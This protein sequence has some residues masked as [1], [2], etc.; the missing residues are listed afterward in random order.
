MDVPPGVACLDTRHPRRLLAPEQVL[1][2]FSIY[3]RPSP[4][5]LKTLVVGYH[6]R[7]SRK[8]E[9]WIII[10]P[11]L[12]EHDAPKCTGRP[13]IDQR[14]ALDAIIFRMRSGC[15]WNSCPRKSSPTT[16][17]CTA[18]CR[19]GS[20]LACSISSGRSSSRSARNSAE[21]TSSGRPPMG[22]WARHTL[23]GSRRPQSHRQSQKRAQTLPAGRGRW[24]SSF[25][26]DS[27]SERA[28]L[29]AVGGHARCPIVVGWP[30]PNEQAPCYEHLC[31]DKGYD[32]APARE[33]VEQR[34]YVPHI[35][36]I[37]E[38]KLDDAGV[39]RYPALGGGTYTGLAVEMPGHTGTLR[40]EG[41]QLP[42]ADQG[43]LHPAVVSAS[44]SSI[45]FEIVC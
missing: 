34:G 37:G 10:E 5:Y 32:K 11:I 44:A 19:G 17:R 15:Q 28:R 35:R 26:G 42:G 6:L 30:A 8:D 22:P 36:K 20:S 9:L 13:C 1:M 45:P 16:P 12:E 7:Y 40:Q 31:L 3:D 25:G 43:G 21:W 27:R 4:N 18:L 38:E 39:K 2:R 24:R 29:Q 33:I 23:G 41:C 14:Q